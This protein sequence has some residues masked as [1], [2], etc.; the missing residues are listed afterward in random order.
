MLFKEAT[1]LATTS[2]EL[3]FTIREI[4][5]SWLIT[6]AVM[7]PPSDAA[8]LKVTKSFSNAPWLLSVT[9]NVLDPLAAAN[10]T[11]PAAVVLRIGVI[12]L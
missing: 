10:V 5:Y 3:V 2:Y 6:A 9:V 7:L 8:P 12:S 1:S 4:W 11:A